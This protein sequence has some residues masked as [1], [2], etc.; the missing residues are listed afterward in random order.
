MGDDG[1]P[2]TVQ[3]MIWDEPAGQ[4]VVLVGVPTD[5]D[6]EPPLAVVNVWSVP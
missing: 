3:E 2:V 6:T 1:V 4:V 5:S